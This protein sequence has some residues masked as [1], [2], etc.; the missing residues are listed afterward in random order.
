[1]QRGPDNP[2]PSPITATAAPSAP[3][4][5]IVLLLGLLIYAAAWIL[6]RDVFQASEFRF[7]PDEIE[8]AFGAH[9]LAETGRFEILINGQWITP[10]VPPWFSMAILAPAYRLLGME[11]GNAIY[12]ITMFGLLGMLLAF[13]V[14]YRVAGAWAGV[15]AALAVFALPTYQHMGRLVTI[16][17]P[18]AVV[19]LATC[20]LYQHMRLHGNDHPPRPITFLLAG[21]IVAC[22]AALR[23]TG[24]ALVLPFLIT[25]GTVHG[26]R[27]RI[28]SVFLLFL[29]L[30]ALATAQL[31][32]NLRAFGSPW[33]SSEHYLDAA[34][35]SIAAITGTW[36]HLTTLTQNRLQALLVLT[37]FIISGLVWIRRT[38]Q[39]QTTETDRVHH[40]API[41]EFLLLGTGPISLIH[42]WQ[43]PGVARFQLPTMVIIMC[44]GAASVGPLLARCRPTYAAV[45]ILLFG[46]KVVHDAILWRS[47][48]VPYSRTTAETIL[49]E[50]PQNAVIIS[51]LP[52]AY[53][54]YMVCRNSSRRIIPFSRYLD[55]PIDPVISAHGRTKTAAVSADIS[56]PQTVEKRF[57]ENLQVR[58]D[59]IDTLVRSGRPVYYT[60]M[61]HDGFQDVDS[62]NILKK[63][64]YQEINQFL[65]RIVPPS[66]NGENVRA[67]DH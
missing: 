40:H 30:T 38:K 47:V 52:P 48:Y 54:E 27:Q 24:A 57:L 66:R 60:S 50:T 55:Y 67:L 17:V 26:T 41:W 51:S 23:S 42:L 35:V 37:A 19:T 7:E 8:Y 3:W 15:A 10:H 62:A 36:T 12:P 39:P 20:W 65:H 11:P 45:I 46:G 31:A 13:G 22:A 28:R 32:Y 29:P 34:S 49:H 9:H 21:T 2:A 1:M 33:M 44:L 64:R 5:L 58:L 43:Y 18:L 25:M 53:L 14:G 56:L 6:H 4:W 61:F 16:D 63:Y 59:Q